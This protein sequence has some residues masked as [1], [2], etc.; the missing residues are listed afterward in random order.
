MWVI[1]Y[2]DFLELTPARK[3]IEALPPVLRRFQPFVRRIDNSLR[4]GNM[5]GVKG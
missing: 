1:V 5:D 3:A 4:A 2:D